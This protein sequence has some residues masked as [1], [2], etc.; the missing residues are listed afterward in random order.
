MR[1][2]QFRSLVLATA[3]LVLISTF[4]PAHSAGRTNQS[5]ANTILNGRGAPTAKI[6]INGDFYIDTNTMNIYGPKTKNLWPKP[7]SL[8]GPSGADGKSGNDGRDGNNG[9]SIS[10]AE[11]ARGPKGDTGPQ[12]LKGDKG[13]KGDPGERGANGAQGSAGLVGATGP[14]GPKGETG[15]AGIA[16]AKGDKGDPGLIGATGATGATGPAGTAGLVGAKGDKG[17][18]GDT[19]LTG[20]TGNQGPK[21]DPGETGAK[22]ET[23]AAGAKG[24]TGAT[25]PSSAIF[26]TVPSFTVSTSSSG[27]GGFSGAIGS[28]AANN[29][30]AF[31]IT[32]RGKSTYTGGNFALEVTAAGVANTVKYDY[33]TAYITELRGSETIKA[34][35]F[36]V[37]G[38]IRVGSAASNLVVTIL[39]GTPSTGVNPMPVT[40]SALITLVG[41]V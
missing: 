25:G 6:G 13:D 7:V 35:Q 5:V 20:T 9:S 17:D 3:S 2:A 23:G 19:G 14:A 4:I 32:L 1:S 10:G 16:G 29:S 8:R 18:K 30:Y 34:Y 21:G 26:T 24:E 41:N 33:T 22:G 36:H 38:T 39:D 27:T 15:A 40:G 12:G 31:Q 28:L 37:I 11:G